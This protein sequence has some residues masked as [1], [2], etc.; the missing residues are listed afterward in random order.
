MRPHTPTQALLWKCWHRTRLQFALQLIITLTIAIAVFLIQ[1]SE[2]DLSAMNTGS[3]GLIF[4][5]LFLLWAACPDVSYR[6]KRDLNI[7]FVLNTDF[8]RPVSTGALLGVSIGYQI[9]LFSLAYLIPT[10]VLQWGFGTAPPNLLILFLI[11]EAVIVFD[12]LQWWSSNS[13]A[14]LVSFLAIL[15]LGWNDYW[16]FPP[17]DTGGPNNTFIVPALATFFIPC[18]TQAALLVLLY[19]GVRAQRMGENLMGFGNGDAVRGSSLQFRVASLLP[20]LANDCPTNSPLRAAIWQENQLRGLVNLCFLGFAMGLLTLVTVS[21]LGS[22]SGFV[23]EIDSGALVGIAAGYYFM[24][25]L[26]IPA[27][28]FEVHPYEGASR[29]SIF[30]FTRPISTARLAAIKIAV[31]TTSLSAGAI[32]MALTIW[33]LGPLFLPEFAEMEADYLQLVQ[34]N[35]TYNSVQSL[36][37][38]ILLLA[39]FASV[40]SVLAAFLTWATVYPR[41]LFWILGGIAAYFLLLILVIALLNEGGDPV[42]IGISLQALMQSHLWL[43][44]VALPLATLYC[45]KEVVRHQILSPQGAVVVGIVAIV[46]AVLA[47]ALTEPGRPVRETALVVEVLTLMRSLL[48]LFAAGLVLWT[49]GRVRHT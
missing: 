12:T 24:L 20:F 1:F 39:T 40:L 9:V 4:A 42:N 46:L 22:I 21:T 19:F 6:L 33:L 36:G 2:P 8:A 35:W 14:T 29:T 5:S 10:L 28:L 38:V 34:V 11:V 26:G 18:L 44:V 16:L 31:V 47:L 41:Q 43:L 13:N 27:G 45:F 7:G 15:L 49:L 48:P 25:F 17:I 3:R 37:A 32:V 30:A 23:K